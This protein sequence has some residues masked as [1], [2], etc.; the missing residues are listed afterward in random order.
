MQ[1]LKAT[2][3]SM[4]LSEHVHFLGRLPD[5]DLVAVLSTADVC[6]NPDE[7]NPMNNMSTMNKVVEYMAL[8]RPQVQFETRE[9]RVSAGESSLY[10][11]PNDSSSFAAAICRLLD[12]AALRE[13]MGALGRQRFT[14]ELSWSRQVP[15]LLAAYG[16]ALSKGPLDVPLRRAAWWRRRQGA[17]GALHEDEPQVARAAAVRHEG[18]S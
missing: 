13:Q 11:V 4:G 3:E 18:T 12:D 16:R 17:V 6:V 8:G 9:G 15:E 5:A 7:V 1:A 10:A 2:S 14:T